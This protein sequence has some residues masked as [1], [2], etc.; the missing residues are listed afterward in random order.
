MKRFAW[1][2]TWGLIACTQEAAPVAISADVR[3]KSAV[4]MNDVSILY[5]LATSADE[6]NDYLKASDKGNGGVLLPEDAFDD[7][8]SRTRGIFSTPSYDQLRVVAMRL[9]P[10]FAN[11]GPVTDP[12]T[13][14]HQMRLVFQPINGDGSASSPATFSDAGF[15]AFYSLDADEFADV[16]KAVVAL[17]IANSTN[18]DLGALDVHPI[19]AKQ[20]LDGAYAAGLASIILA[21]AGPTTLSRV[22]GFIGVFGQQTQ[23][24]FAADDI[25]DGKLVTSP[26]FG[27]AGPGDSESIG[28]GVAP[29]GLISLNVPATT[30]SDDISP[31]LSP[32]SQTFSDDQRNAALNAALRIQNPNFHSPNTIDCASCHAA[33]IASQLV[34][35]DFYKVSITG[36][37]NVYA[38]DA[39]YITV[40][41]F[42]SKYQATQPNGL[43]VNLHAFSYDGTAPMIIQRVVNETAAIVAYLDAN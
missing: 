3:A 36:D 25:T 42:A 4:Q 8:V 40:R 28:L 17:R 5:P 35:Q 12:S 32:N 37:A 7:L 1:L 10:C 27:I 31:L 23:W 19:M 20:G 26:V 24:H 21:H 18:S 30:T 34:A 15:H 14:A 16:V 2:A 43:A 9:D 11:I 41:D 33:Q 6:M 29:T 22:T 38:R 39:R 13:C